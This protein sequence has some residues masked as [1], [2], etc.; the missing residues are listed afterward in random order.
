MTVVSGLTSLELG[1]GVCRCGG[2]DSPL[3]QCPLIGKENAV[4]D[5]PSGEE[6]SVELTK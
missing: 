6:I 1:G 5:H 3:A 2:C 4:Q